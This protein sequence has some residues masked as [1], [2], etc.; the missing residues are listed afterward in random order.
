M[1]LDFSKK[2]LMYLP[3]VL[4]QHPW[5]AHLVSLMLSTNEFSNIPLELFELRA[6]QKLS[7]ACNKISV[8]P[9][10]ISLLSGAQLSYKLFSLFHI[11]IL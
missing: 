6:L 3:P 9:P 10:Q 7:I 1:Y 5:T 8:I 4:I 11:L 2:G